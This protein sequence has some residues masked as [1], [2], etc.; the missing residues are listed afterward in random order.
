MLRPIVVDSNFSLIIGQRRLQANKMLGKDS[1][2]TLVIAL[3]ALIKDKNAGY[4]LK[5]YFTLSEIV[6]IGISL[7]AAL[8]KR[9]GKRNDLLLRPNSDEVKG[10]TDEFIA[11]LLKL[12]SK[13]SY[14]QAKKVIKN[15]NR[16]LIDL[17]DE[18]KMSISAAAEIANL[19]KE[20]QQAFFLQHHHSSIEKVSQSTVKKYSSN[21]I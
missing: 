18:E 21:K 7:E 16:V 9:Q 13:N 14:R 1:I 4:Q 20:E 3:E 6:S 5:K 11:D 19:S 2:S 8:G 12:G 15:G 10:R 17:M